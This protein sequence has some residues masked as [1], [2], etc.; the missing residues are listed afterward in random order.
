MINEKVMKTFIKPAV[1]K[2][3]LSHKRVTVRRNDCIC[4]KCNNFTYVGL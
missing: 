3:V 4:A 2:M 1:E